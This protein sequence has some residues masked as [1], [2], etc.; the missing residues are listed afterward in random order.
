MTLLVL[1]AFVFWA[2]SGFGNIKLSQFPC[3]LYGL[4]DIW[5]RAIGCVQVASSPVR[6]TRFS[7]GETKA[8]GILWGW[9][10]CHWVWRWVGVVHI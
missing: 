4:T 2:L 3:S 6:V 1:D 5:N 9:G 8:F 7:S 10:V